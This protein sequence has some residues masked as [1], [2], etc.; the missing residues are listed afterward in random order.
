MCEVLRG[1]GAARLKETP[2]MVDFARLGVTAERILDF[3]TGEF[4]GAYKGNRKDASETILEASLV[5]IRLRDLMSQR[6]EWEGTASELLD[7]LNGLAT[8]AERRRRSWPSTPNALGGALARLA[9]SFRQVGIQIDR[10]REGHGRRRVMTICKIGK[11]SSA[12]SAD[13]YRAHP[14]I[15]DSPGVS[16]SDP[17]ADK[18]DKA[19][20]ETRTLEAVEVR[21]KEWEV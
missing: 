3:R 11:T 1:V 17:V 18:A 13:P 19:D 20:N 16:D 8:D 12:S 5:A 9:P 4:M 14:E 15:V 7:A 2:R 6:P 10:D 21:E